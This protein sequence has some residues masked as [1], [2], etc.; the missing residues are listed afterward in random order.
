MAEHL[1]SEIVERYQLRLL[2]AVARFEADIH[3]AN[4][5]QCRQQLD[6]A[7]NLKTLYNAFQSNLMYVTESVSEHFSGEQVAAY[8][9]DKFDEVETEI[10][11]SHLNWCASCTS[12]VNETRAI[13][14]SFEK[15]PATL[16]KK[17]STVGSLQQRLQSH[18][19]KTR[20]PFYVYVAGAFATVML[21][22][23]LP[24]ALWTGFFGSK[25]KD[26]SNISIAKKSNQAPPEN[27][28]KE[29]SSSDP[30]NTTAT[31]VATQAPPLP[32]SPTAVT[33][34]T[35]SPVS[36]APVSLSWLLP[37]DRQ[38]FSKAVGSRGEL[39]VAEIIPRLH[40]GVT[41]MGR[42]LPQSFSLLRPLGE[43][44][45]DTQPVIKWEKLET[46]E[47]Y[48]VYISDHGVD[49]KERKKTFVDRFVTDTEWT[50]DRVLERG[51]LYLLQ[52]IAI[53][54][55]GKVYGTGLNDT[56]TVFFV[57]PEAE[58]QRVKL[59]EDH[60]RASR[61]PQAHLAL[62]IRYAKAGLIDEARREFNAYLEQHPKSQIV[63]RLLASLNRQANKK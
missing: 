21:V 49:G 31:P 63:S 16:V 41:N 48:Q 35:D 53:T 25:Q 52:V 2:T 4:C 26:G 42:T 17:I 43:V 20:R 3:L 15:E 10:A 57:M 46:A 9:G 62:G 56:S 14:L 6:E 51:H 1:S 58:A 27:T 45:R 19:D 32:H 5:P 54:P 55:E 39:E 11:T 8:V 37:N 40:N 33:I 36:E 50:I 34:G 13:A 29:S 28:S 22:L 23:A 61:N 12:E 38:L 59:A 44:I 18:W 7:D 47:R 24:Y 60:Y 30:A